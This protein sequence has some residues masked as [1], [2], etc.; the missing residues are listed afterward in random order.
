MRLR[1]LL[2]Y[3]LTWLLIF[4]NQKI[5]FMLVNMGLADGAPFGSCVAAL[6]HG[7][8]LDLVTASYLAII[9]TLVVLVSYFFRRFPLRRVLAPYYWLTAVVIAVAFLADTILYFFWGAKLD[10]NE[11][12]YVAKPKDMLASLPV[13]QAVLAFVLMGAVAWHYFRR[14]RHATP[15]ELTAPLSRLA[16]LWVLPLAALIFLGMRGSISQSTANPSYAYFSPH[17][18]CNH[19]ALNPTFNILHSLFKTQDIEKE[20]DSLTDSDMDALVGDAYDPDPSI[21]DTLLAL[22]RPNVLFIIWEG[23]GTAMV[24]SDSVAPCLQAL[25]REGVYFSN[26]YANS[27]RTDRGILSVL[28]GW[29]GMPTLSLIKRTDLC[30]CLPSVAS[31]LRDEGYATSL[32][33]GGDVDYANMRLYFSETGF[34][35]VR[36]SHFFP[37]SQSTSA[38]GVHDQ[39]LLAPDVLIPAKRPFFSAALTL[40]SHEPWEVPMQRLQHPRWNSFAY[41]DSCLGAFVDRLKASPLWDSL[42]VV[43]LPDHGI[44]YPGVHSTAD[45][46]VSHIPML[47]VGGALAKHGEYDMLLNQSDLAATLLAQMG[48]DISDFTFSRNVFS[49]SFPQ[50]RQFAMHA[51]KN[52]VTLIQPDGHWVYDCVSRSLQ[53]VSEPQRLF[54]EASLQRLYQTSAALPKHHRTSRPQ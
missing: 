6:W 14:Q 22:Q 20:F 46:R 25:R 7:L 49:P 5:V 44:T 45:L 28:S 2:R 24:G 31:S 35:T 12:L 15:V 32:T 16:F 11:L 8:R 52:G 19:A 17:K 23:A 34:S 4:V 33:Y 53:P 10:A 50:R 29:P 54:I 30:R 38:W 3:F 26:C 43:I 18:F 51:D 41:T 27:F 47:W 1:Y 37:A 13:W 42:L 36:G 39:Y 40:S 9:P 48:V 21:A